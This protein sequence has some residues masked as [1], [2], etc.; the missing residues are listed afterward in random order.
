M[1][2]ALTPPPTLLVRVARNGGLGAKSGALSFDKKL[3]F[4]SGF[5]H[6]RELDPNTSQVNVTSSPSHANCLPL[7]ISEFSNTLAAT[8]GRIQ[9]IIWDDFIRKWHFSLVW[10]YSSGQ[11]KVPV[12]FRYCERTTLINVRVS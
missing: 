3:M 5:L 8:V 10:I 7:P 12:P 6:R 9:V 4:I 1:K 11:K 2:L